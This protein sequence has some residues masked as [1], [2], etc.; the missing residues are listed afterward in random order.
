MRQAQTLS[1]L[2][3]STLWKL[4]SEGKLDVVR[5]YG[6]TLIVMASLRRLLIPLPDRIESASL[7]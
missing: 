1:N 6:R 2:S 5:V 4:V 7:R 3:L